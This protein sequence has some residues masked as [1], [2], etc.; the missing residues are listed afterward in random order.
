[1]YK[2][3]NIILAVSLLSVVLFSAC[4]E[5]EMQIPVVENVR[6]VEKDSSITG[7]EFGTYL[8]L[9][10]RGFDD[11]VDVVF[12]TVIADL[13]INYVTSNNIIVQVPTEYPEE[14]ND[15]VTLITLNG[16]RYDFP[17]QIEVP[18]PAIANISYQL[19]TNLILIEGESFAHI[20]KLTLGGVEITNY[21][22]S[23]GLDKITFQLPDGVPVGV[24]KVVIETPAG[25]AETDF[26]LEAA[27]SP[28][29]INIPVEWVEAGFNMRINGINLAR[30][31]KVTINGTIDVTSGFETNDIN[32]WLEFPMPADVPSGDMTI[33][34]TNELGSASNKV[35]STY[36]TSEYLWWNYDDVAYCWGAPASAVGEDQVRPVSAKFGMFQGDIAPS[37][38]DQNNMFNG[39]FDVPAEIV[40]S[41]NDYVLKFEVNVLNPWSV[42]VFRISFGGEGG[43]EQFGY[44]W[45]PY[46]DGESFTSEGWTTVAIPLSEWNIDGSS[47]ILN[48]PRFKFFI[49]GDATNPSEN[50]AIY[51]D[52]I[53][54]DSL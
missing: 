46:A 6:V 31:S 30:I 48:N 45:K 34:V 43:E 10:G 44:D 2:I 54:I 38:W 22:V 8:A 28:S 11:V 36:K 14:V 35:T 21:E 19:A 41:P 49:A 24:I 5:D 40:S 53:R 27:S 50:T 51:I 52:N 29:I 3:K 1:M 17:F 39:C 9:Q 12:N 37:W 7:A 20:K 18:E 23:T 32:S 33:Q 15:I 42:G 4:S 47:A 16:T 25:T 26:D 13:N